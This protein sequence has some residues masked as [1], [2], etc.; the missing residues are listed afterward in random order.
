MTY[1]N[2]LLSEEDGIIV[3]TFNREKALNALNYQTLEE[4]KYF[5]AEDAPNREGLIGVILTG[6]GEKSFVAGADITE[7]LALESTKGG[8]G[9]LAQRGQDIFFLIENF[10]R[11]VIAAVNGFALGGGCELAMACHMRIAGA[12]ARFGQP[13]VN[14]GIIPG[15]G[16]TQRLIQYIGKGKAIELMMTGDMIG[17]EEAHRLGLANHQVEAGQEVAKAKEILLKVAQKAPIAI[18][19]V[20]KCVN[21]YFEPGRDGFDFEVAQFDLTTQTE[22]FTEGATAFVERRKANF[23]GS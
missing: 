17:A 12:K 6:A 10:H 1:Q 4:L 18:S 21:K 13:E 8:G 16:G 11:P 7:F 22:D 3:L 15:Y 20:I 2:I 23:K 5:F 14:L 19:N 9:A